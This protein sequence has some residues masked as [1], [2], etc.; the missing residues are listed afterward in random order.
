MILCCRGCLHCRTLGS[1]LGLYSLEA[2]STPQSCQSKMSVDIVKW[3]LKAKL[4]PPCLVEDHHPIQRF[5][6]CWNIPNGSYPQYQIEHRG[7]IEQVLRRGHSMWQCGYRGG[8][9]GMILPEWQA[10]RLQS[11]FGK[12][13]EVWFF[14]LSRN[15][16][17]SATWH[18]GRDVGWYLAGFSVLM[19]GML[20]KQKCIYLFNLGLLFP[21]KI[22]TAEHVWR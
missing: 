15:W 9:E 12:R 18:E 11:G 19:K 1:T 7:H 2:R 3:P 22:E 14:F 20:N 21:F 13:R 5:D 17:F 6:L 16:H 4:R 10:C 8:W